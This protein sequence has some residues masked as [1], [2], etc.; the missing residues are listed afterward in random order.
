M[1][2]ENPV[3][4]E[5][6]KLTQAEQ[7][8]TVTEQELLAVVHALR[9]FRCYCL[10]NPTRMVTDHKANT[11]LQEQKTLSSRQARWS[12]FLQD[13]DL[14]WEYKPGA[15]NPADPLSRKVMACVV[16][17]LT[18]GRS[19]QEAAA[20]QD[21]LSQVTARRQTGAADPFVDT[22]GTAERDALLSSVQ[23][24][25]KEDPWFQERR[26][27]K[28]LKEE[29]GYWWKAGKDQDALV[30]PKV[31]KAGQEDKD[32]KLKIVSIFHDPPHAG[33][34]GIQGTA[35]AIQRHYWWPGLIGTVDDY[36]SSCD[37]CQRNKVSTLAPAGMLKP[38]RIPARKWE[39]ASMDF[40]TQLPR[41]KAGHDAILVVVDRLTKLAH[42]IS[43]TSDVDAKGTAEL[44]DRE[45]FRL[46]G[47]PEE[48]L[49]DRGTQFTSAIFTGALQA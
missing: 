13:Y 20:P 11:F 37:L 23:E 49:T 9:I 29:E 46:H 42:F 32:L 26:N 1:Q 39:C 44:F 10:G 35:Q 22:I 15:E 38:L 24:G 30:I 4:F 16:L 6:R 7:H 47:M 27:R 43:T 48:I 8:Y 33:H 17:I 2:E 34:R 14:T 28:K 36:I 45:I 41:T 19:C 31:Y 40:I 12:T 18:R 21:V 5:S 25:Y 3:A